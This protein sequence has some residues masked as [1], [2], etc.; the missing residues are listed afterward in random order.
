MIFQFFYLLDIPAVIGGIRVTITITLITEANFPFSVLSLISLAIIV[1]ISEDSN[2]Y[3]F[4]IIETMTLI[5]AGCSVIPYVIWFTTSKNINL[6]SQR[7][8][9]DTNN[10]HLHHN[11][12]IRKI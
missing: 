9:T 11:Y 5:F 12:Y 7:I 1:I 10:S 4:T 3:V 2:P 6:V 8:R